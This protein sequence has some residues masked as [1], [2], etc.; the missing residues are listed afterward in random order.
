M[1][2]TSSFRAGYLESGVNRIVDQV[3]EQKMDYIQSKVEEI[4]YHYVGIAKPLKK[5][6]LS[7][8][9]VIDTDLMPT[10]LEQVSPDVL[11]DEVKDE[12]V[13]EELVE[14]DDFESPAFEPIESVIVEK[15]DNSEHSNLSAISG[16][17]SE[18][19]AQ[20]KSEPMDVVQTEAPDVQDQH[21]QQ[22]SQISQFSSLQDTLS[23]EASDVAPAVAAI[24]EEAQAVLTTNDAIQPPV[25]LDDEAQVS[26]A[27]DEE[28]QVA[29][30]LNVEETNKDDQP[31]DS[32]EQPEIEDPNKSQFDLNKD[33]IEFTGTERKSISLDDS[34]NST[35]AEKVL[36]PQDV[37]ANTMEVDNL[38]SNDT[39]DSGDVKMEIDLKDD[40]TQ[41]TVESSSKVEESSQDSSK[42]AKEKSQSDHK[43]D[44][45]HDHHK[46]DRSRDKH[47]SSS[48]HKSSHHSRSS[49]SKGR[50]DDKH[51]SRSDGKSSGSSSRKKSSSEKDRS[52]SSRRDHDKDRKSRD[53]NSR[54]K[55]RDSKTSDDHQQEKSSSR[56]RRSTDHDSNDGKTLSDKTRG[57][58]TSSTVVAQSEQVQPAAAVDKALEVEPSNETTETLENK[59]RI[60]KK[61]LS[62][63]SETS[64]D[65]RSGVKRSSILIK[66][67]YLKSPSKSFEAK[68]EKREIE[69]G[70]RGFE[71]ERLPDNPWF[72]CLRKETGKVQ[73]KKPKSKSSNNNY[74]EQQK[75]DK[76]LNLDLPKAKSKQKQKNLDSPSDATT[77]FDAKLTNGSD[78]ASAGARAHTISQ[79]Q[80]YTSEDLFKPRF[81]FGNRNRRRGGAVEEASIEEAAKTSNELEIPS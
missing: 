45:R 53:D 40:T 79:Q 74:L 31:S 25:A 81:N 80:R 22:D 2:L 20:S 23:Q 24:G 55:N 42:V 21:Q 15:N 46:S 7:E 13:E 73:K 76:T 1:T 72:T 30:A 78:E 10:D 47:K 71:V 4:L 5:E 27:L 59:E 26:A 56:R 17:T 63:S 48:S 54:S 9:L 65:S 11:M 50:H 60:V 66:Y 69:D 28:A 3:M 49:S 77:S 41:G 6:K 34:A 37:P 51:K 64:S 16:L 35:E 33:S 67:D 43:K 38:Y 18:N 70:F 14:D 19:S 57:E 39:T 75:Q 29:P 12:E 58:N 62:E 61:M 36:Q 44:S 68:R 32:T 8:G 52:S